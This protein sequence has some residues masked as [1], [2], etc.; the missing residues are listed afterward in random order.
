MRRRAT[1]IL[2]LLLASIIAAGIGASQYLRGADAAGAILYHPSASCSGNPGN[3]TLN[4]TPAPGSATQTLQIS[5]YD[6]DF[7]SGTFTSVK[8]GPDAT[9]HSMAALERDIPS[10]WRIVSGSGSAE[11]ASE[12]SAF[13]PCG[14]PFLLWGPL[15]CRNFTSAAVRFRW[16]PS[17]NFTGQQWLE[18]DSDGDWTGDDFWTAGPY[19]PS[20]ETVRRSGF[21]N[22]VG[23]LF[24]VVRE[25]DGQRQV[26]SVGWFMPDCAPYVNP[27]NY[28]TDDRLV[29]PAI[30]VDAPVNIRDV[31][32][33]GVLGV[34]SGGQDVIKY[35]FAYLPNLQ[36][37]IG[38]PGAALIAGHFDY[39]V[40][41]PAVFWD[42]AQL[43]AG[44][45]VEY[46]DGG[47]K[48][49]YV[50]DWV[51]AVPFSQALNGYIESSGDGTLI[52]VTC[53]GEFDREQFGGYDQRTLVHTTLVN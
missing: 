49:V 42:L 6:N 22:N 11:V 51:T 39:Y 25:L 30:S 52:L 15:E 26:S 10:Y 4:W 5:V 21:Q 45:V 12:T 53:F 2:P 3:V 27:D 7:E 28:G 37:Q 13:V 23:Y 46:W 9:T 20:T 36:G 29:I 38:G 47:V 31:G 43:K 33:D 8:L 32:L 41:G 24:R 40:I 17:A 35:N 44:D 34:P 14:G 50:V 16:A 19:S 1:F 18:F 48:Y